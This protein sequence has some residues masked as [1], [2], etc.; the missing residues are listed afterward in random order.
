MELLEKGLCNIVCDAKLKPACKVLAPKAFVEICKFHDMGNL[1]KNALSKNLK[2]YDK[3]SIGANG[4]S[5]VNYKCIE[6]ND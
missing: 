2:Y 3:R 1:L 4:K 6:P 5:E